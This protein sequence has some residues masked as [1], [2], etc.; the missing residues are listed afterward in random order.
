MTALPLLLGVTGHRDIDPGDVGVA[1]AATDHLIV[2]LTARYPRTPVVVLSAL[3]EGSDQ[4]V[5]HVAEVHG[6]QVVCPLPMPVEAYRL[7]FSS[8]R[9]RTDFDQL[10]KRFQY[11]V[12]T[13]QGSPD[14]QFRVLGNALSAFSH[15]LVAVW[16]GAPADPPGGTADTVRMRLD[17]ERSA[18]SRIDLVY[19]VPV[20]RTADSR[21]AQRVLL[22][23][24]AV[25]LTGRTV[26]AELP[27][28]SAT[29]FGTLDRF[30][31][32]S[33]T[34]ASAAPSSLRPFV[35]SLSWLETAL[36]EQAWR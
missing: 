11:F 31:A 12:L 27:T 1:M 29:L 3:A 10:L 18:P 19:H 6:V 5:A 4:L 20:R 23:E 9:A 26:S 15:I 14:E 33:G 36:G 7:T 21:Q 13:N 17:G 28:A 16:D 32:A 24:H 35:D 25:F 22:R 8:E 30:N 34:A 2:Q